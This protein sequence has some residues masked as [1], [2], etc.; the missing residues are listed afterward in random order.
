MLG[1]STVTFVGQDVTAAKKILQD[2]QL[3]AAEHEKIMSQAGIPVFIVDAASY[4][5]E[6]ND[7]M[8]DITG[9]TK[10]DAV[11]QHLIDDLVSI[12]MNVQNRPETKTK[13]REQMTLTLASKPASYEIGR[14]SCRERV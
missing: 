3:V 14:A 10:R 11:G 4:I 9:I 12:H 5:L 6:W 1:A 8:A 13:L 7:T 2:C